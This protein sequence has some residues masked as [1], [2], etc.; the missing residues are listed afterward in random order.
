M[1]NMPKQNFSKNKKL[2]QFLKSNCKTLHLTG[3]GFEYLLKNLTGMTLSGYR[4]PQQETFFI[5]SGCF[6]LAD[7]ENL[8]ICKLCIESGVEIKFDGISLKKN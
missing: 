1:P 2:R 3:D 5:L 7:E 8:D 6:S 4:K